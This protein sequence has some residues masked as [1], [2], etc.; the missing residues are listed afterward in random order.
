MSD[1]PNVQHY[2]DREAVQRTRAD[3]AGDPE[4]KQR[5]ESLADA[6]ARVARSQQAV[7]DRDKKRREEDEVRQKL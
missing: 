1:R 3:Q 7:Q 4:A 2:L 5:L 6:Y